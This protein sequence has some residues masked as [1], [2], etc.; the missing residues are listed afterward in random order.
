MAVA[1]PGKWHNWKEVRVVGDHGWNWDRERA[2]ESGLNERCLMRILRCTE[3]WR[4]VECRV[5]SAGEG[6]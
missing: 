3:G 4:S 2:F 1:A 5:R 6:V